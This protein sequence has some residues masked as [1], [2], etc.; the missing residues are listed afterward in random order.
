LLLLG[1]VLLIGVPIGI[2]VIDFRLKTSWEVEDFLNTTLAGEICRIRGVKKKRRPHIVSEESK[3]NICEGFRGIYSRLEI[4]SEVIYPKVI[5]ISSTLPNEGKSVIT[6]N[7]AS[8]FAMHGRRTLMVDA[9]LRRPSLNGFHDLENNA[10]LLKWIRGR[11]PV[12]EEPLKDETLGIVQVEENLSLLRSGGSEKRPTRYFEN[13]RL[14]ALFARLRD[15]FDVIIVD[16]PPMGVFSDSLLLSRYCDEILFVVR[17]NKTG[18]F[19]IRATVDRIYQSDIAMA[20]VV[21]NGIPPGNSSSYYGYRGY[22]TYSDEQYAAYER[23]R[24]E[25]A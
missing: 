22:G 21:L 20:G 4:G 12:P 11:E 18:K 8:T 17:F 24:E 15:N 3:Q 6:A 16:S 25:K 9:D 19:R 1:F 14:N 7:L 5:L 13:E 23:Q 2:G 10:G